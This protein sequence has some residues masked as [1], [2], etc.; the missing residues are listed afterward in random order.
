LTNA[1]VLAIS[2]AGE[3]AVLLNL[4]A[5]GWFIH[6]GTLAR[7]P[8]AGGTPRE[9][10]PD[11]QEAD[12]SPDGSEIAVVRSVPEGNRL[13]FPAGKALFGTSGYISHPR[14][15][16]DGQRVAFLEHPLQWDNRGWVAE[17]DRAGKKRR[18][19]EEFVSLEGLEW[20]SDGTE[21]W[22]SA[23]RTGEPWFLQA[24]ALNGR[25]RQV[26]SD[27]AG[28]LLQDISP[29]GRVLVSRTYEFIQHYVQMPGETHERSLP[30]PDQ[31]TIM[32]L[33][34]D[35]KSFLVQFW[36]EGTGSNYL[37]GLVKADGSAPVRLG[38][39]RT[40][41][42]SPDGRWIATVL[43]ATEKVQLLPTG[44]GEPK[45]IRT[46]GLGCVDV[47]F[48]P[49]GLHLVIQGREK[50]QSFRYYVQEIEGT[51][52][53][54]I[55]PDLSGRLP[56]TFLSPDGRYALARDGRGGGLLYPVNGGKPETVVG[57]KSSD[58]VVGWTADSVS[59]FVKP[60][61]SFPVPIER[62]DWATGRRT[63][64]KRLS[65]P[66]PAGIFKEAWVTIAPDEQ[67]YTYSVNRMFSRL[68]VA[69]G[70]K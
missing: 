67:S 61:G 60:G 41:A 48:L 65:P 11:V 15:S 9:W 55:T 53:R 28:L 54:A 52:R 64:W 43:P 49:D 7:M 37:L 24:V 39:G 19:T 25:Q 58:Q 23:S 38:E 14:V 59:V 17:V 62:L 69:E 45:Q 50:D 42:M 33:A 3:L 8:L 22:F 31:T 40:S 2:S 46:D 10:I 20:S 13:E 16:P 30:L 70:L 18:L 5:Q 44:A 66:D 1:D 56:A 63:L 6:R 12:W 26:T 27:V 21:V 4:E 51:N 34:P 57:L 29:D 68:Y 47:Q 32:G 36:A 35:G